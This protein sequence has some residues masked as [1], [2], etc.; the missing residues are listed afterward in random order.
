MAYSAADL[1]IMKLE[2]SLFLD[3]TTVL[4]GNSGSGKSIFITD[5]LYT[6]RGHAKQI[7]VVSPTDLSNKVYSSGIVEL[8]FIH[9]HIT[10]ELLIKMWKQQEKYAKIYAIVNDYDNISKLFLKLNDKGAISLIERVTKEKLEKL[11]A[12]MNKFLDVDVQNKKKNEIEKNYKEFIHTIR[13]K[14]LQMYK[15]KLT[16]LT[17]EETNILKHLDFN[18]R[19]VL[20]LDDCTADIKDIKS[21]EAKQILKKM[22]YQGRHYFVTIILAIHDD[23]ALPGELRNN[24][25]ISLFM[26]PRM[27]NV[28][29][30]RDTNGFSRTEKKEIE[31]MANDVFSVPYQKLVFIKNENKFY[32]TMATYRE[33]DS[34]QFLPQIVRNY[35]DNI[36]STKHSNPFN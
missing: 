35:C 10:D 26:E 13:K 29:F 28:Y 27:I 6:L 24:A 31:K 25:Y 5:L 30:G 15:N 2:T 3:K 19:L 4:Y 14:Y 9:Y 23:K 1:P 20:V 21:F 8:P 22:F 7:L 34:F 33:K 12:V 32:K 18:P 17:E 36:I 16:N 11:A